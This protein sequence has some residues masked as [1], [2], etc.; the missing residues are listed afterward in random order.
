MADF[1]LLGQ[2]PGTSVQ[3]TFWGWLTVLSLS[4]VLFYFWY[5]LFHMRRFWM[6]MLY[7]SLRSSIRHYRPN[8]IG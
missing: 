3:I 4:S 8:P 5:S 2:I 6:A 7:V 1:L